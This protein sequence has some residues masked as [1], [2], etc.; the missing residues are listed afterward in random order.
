MA[1]AAAAVVVVVVEV[2]VSSGGGG[3]GHNDSDDDDDDDNNNN[4]NNNRIE[5]RN[6][7]YLGS[8]HCAAN[9]LQHVRSSGPGAIVCKSRAAHRTLIACNLQCATWYEGTAQL[10]SWTE[11]KPHLC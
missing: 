1:A 5:R 7:R 10:L 8:S 2:V 3:G 11:M 9:C 4:N 6:S